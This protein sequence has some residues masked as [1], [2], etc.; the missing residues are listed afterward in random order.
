MVYLDLAIFTVTRKPVS[1]CQ[2]ATEDWLRMW[3]WHQ[4]SCIS[5]RS[6]RQ[7]QA[8]FTALPFV[9]LLFEKGKVLI[10]LLFLI[11]LLLLIF[12]V[13]MVKLFTFLFLEIL[14][15]LNYN[16]LCGFS[17]VYWT[18]SS[19]FV[20][21]WEFGFYRRLEGKNLIKWRPFVLV[22]RPSSPNCRQP[23]F[24]GPFDHFSSPSFAFFANLFHFFAP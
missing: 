16:Y 2:S 21:G 11:G 20:I 24:R 5:S 14:E 10:F 13:C 7:D 15:F 6:Y 23:L 18:K 8:H 9:Y 19:Y 22:S 4:A 17:T 1:G 12:V 3:S